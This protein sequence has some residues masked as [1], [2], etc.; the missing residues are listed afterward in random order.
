MVLEIDDHFRRRFEMRR[1]EAS[2]SDLRKRGLALGSRLG[3]AH[4]W[5]SPTT[6]RTVIYSLKAILVRDMCYAGD[7]QP[8]KI[9]PPEDVARRLGQGS[10]YGGTRARISPV[11]SHRAVPCP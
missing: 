6:N 10:D 4:H 5:I 9:L 7:A 1:Q 2:G 11:S 8:E 3:S